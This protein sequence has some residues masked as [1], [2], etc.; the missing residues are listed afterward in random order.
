MRKLHFLRTL[1]LVIF[2]TGISYAQDFSNKGKDFWVGYGYH[3]V[4]NGNNA[5]QMVLYFAADQNT[6][7]TVTIPGL[8]YSQNY[9]VAANSVLTS[10]PLPKTG[11]QDARLLSESIAG[12][13]KGIHIVSDKPIVAYAHIYNASVS[14]ASILFPTA[15]LGK[16]YY[17][18]NYTNISNT[19][20]SNCWFYVVAV[21]TGTTT[22][23][24]TPSAATINHS[25]GIPF[26][27]TLQQGQI[28]N[29]MGQ[30]SGNSG[31]DLTGSKIQSINTGAGCKRIGVFSGSGRISITCNG[32]SS[33]SDNYMVQAFPKTAWGKKFLTVSTG[34]NQSNNIYRIC[35]SDPTTV[36][37]L[38]GAPIGLPLQG[39]FYYEIA[40]SNTPKKIE[41]DKPIMVAQYMTSAGACGN[42]GSPGDP[43]VIYLS[44]VEQ[45]INKVLWNATPNFSIQQHY[46]NVVIPNSGT[47]ISSFKLDGVQV[48]PGLFTVHPQDPAYSYLVQSVSAG[49]HTIE[50]DSGFNAIAYG[51][52]N[53]ESYGYN[54]GTNIKDIYQF[55]SIQ[56]PEAS[57]NFP[58][59]CIGTPFHFSMTFPYQPTSIKWQFGAALNAQGIT[60]VTIP[61]PVP[62]S[63][64]VVNGRTL[65]TYQLPGTYQISTA[66]TYPIR[67]VATNP[68]PDGCG[69]IQEIDFDL[70]V[71]GKPVADFNFSSNGCINS[72]VLF[73]DNS[74]SD[75]RSFI[76]WHW[77]F[78]DATTATITNP[79]H[80]YTAPGSYNVK[81]A[82]TT[83]IGCVSDTTTHVVT[84]ND[85]PVALFSVSP[86]TCEDQVVTFTD[87]S[88][89]TSGGTLTQ[90]TW[91]F[92]DG[93]PVVVRSTST[94]ETHTYTTPGNYIATL[95]VVSSSGCQSILFSMP[96]T[97]YANP[98]VDYN[99]P[100]ACMPSGSAQFND[101]SSAPAGSTITS[102]VWDFGDASTSTLQNPLHNYTA[103]GPF[104]IS[105]TVTT[106]NGCSA[107]KEQILNTIY[108]EPVAAFS[109]LPQVCIGSLIGFSDNSTASGS[110]VTGWNWDFGDGN[111]STLQ[112]PTHI[113]ASAGSYTVT[114]HVTSA[115]GCQTVSN[116]ATHTV[117]VNPLP[118]A[119]ISGTTT[120]CLN[121]PSPSI[122]FTGVIGV[123]PF[124]FTYNINGGPDLIAV[125][126][127]GNSVNVAVPTSTAGTF[128]YNLISVKEGSASGCV[129]PQT[130]SASVTV[131]QLPV[132][133]IGG[134]TTVCL[135]ASAPL[136]TFTGT[137]G[138]APYTFSYN[139][140]GGAT[141]TVTTTIGNSVTVPVSTAT[142]GTFTYNLLSIQESSSNLCSQN[143]SGSA[144][145]TV[146]ALPT[147]TIS[148]S[149]EVCL[150]AASP[151]ITFS[152]A[153]GSAPY[154]FNYSI[155]GGATQ[156]INS[157]TSNSVTIPVS[158]T[159]AGTFS[160]SLI[161]VT[162]GSSNS[163]SQVQSGTADVIVNP[164]PTVD[165]SFTSPQ[166]ET[167]QIAFSDL[168]VA[169][170]GVVNSW[171]WNFGD[172]A[173]GAA[174]TST[175]Q[176][177]THSYSTPGTYTVSLAVNTDKSCA[178]S[179]FTNTVTISPRPSAGFI[180]PEVCL[181][182]LASPFVDTSSVEGGTIVAWEWNF[183]DANATG[184]NPNTSTLQ[185]PTHHFTAVGPYT[186]QLIVTSNTGCKDTIQQTFTV[187][188]SVPIAGFTVQ[189][190]SSLC[191]NQDVQIKDASTVDYGS[192]VK[193]EIYWDYLNNPTIKTT[194]DNPIPGQVYNHTYPEFGTPFTKTYQIRYVAYS[195]ISCVN[196]T[197]QT[198]TVLATP[199]LQFNTIPFAC[200]NAPAFQITQAQLMNGLPGAGV[201]S[202]AGVTGAGLF[203]PSTGPGLYTVRYTYTGTNG[204]ENYLEQTVN[205]FATPGI[206]AG[207]DKFVLEGGQVTLSPASNASQPLTFSWTP[208]IGLNDPTIEFPT[209]S[210]SDDVTY[211]LT[212]TTPQGCSA[213]D[214]VFVKVLKSLLIPNIFS[215]NGD[216][217]HDR[218]EIPY[219]ESYPGCTIEVVNRYGQLVFRSIGYTTPWDG[220]VNGKDVPVGTYYYVID[221][222]NGRSR[223]NGYV[224]VIR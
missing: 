85:P 38:N 94:I 191:S 86:T 79:S 64:A 216:G 117:V 83:D 55:L 196:T 144:I 88:S 160:Y 155:N 42:G 132:A 181:T 184:S 15:T 224:D 90:W 116:F 96:V 48:S 89:I 188:G 93:S 104:N 135:N 213:S 53:A 163:C 129:Q 110:T 4:M 147:A 149:T 145:V 29:I 222:K 193:V 82:V 118:T 220:K 202:G 148:G 171:Q 78:G 1:L 58:A 19:S 166:C 3:Q 108:P 112:N 8:G 35:V 25:A 141:Q 142:A 138:V 49:K 34:G 221:P 69:G 179:T 131:N 97:I 152:G 203:N 151:T 20:N 197:T 204:C 73:T 174:N 70:Q 7:V 111:T 195:G 119:N 9:F 39:N 57:V 43:E 92:G 180:L 122:V 37:T 215:P 209:A 190:A 139:I 101:L 120:V 56:N 210:P 217:S 212:V 60:D 159:T 168:S 164:L 65:Y 67:V 24:I 45:N 109:S 134:T 199:S 187:N 17:S 36:V 63:T 173:S 51:Y 28:Y 11:A 21:D 218:W 137:S 211:T 44:P 198:I 75:G 121:S 178:S 154:T 95:A 103:A 61:S 16:E 72:P 115:E 62:T 165:F 59:T 31:V 10:N 140:N 87:Q 5:Q 136:I 23:E 84:I 175:L 128:T 183:G 201:F 41:A 223:L 14:G 68:T 106:N 98:V 156:L 32:T 71:Y 123:A 143:Q 127:T 185:N 102:W 40:A 133:T 114:L 113:Y 206:N 2:T 208:P 130:S 12:E 33:S 126:T 200:S 107:I 50:S 125:T 47:A 27:V 182:D 177:P 219:L 99:L 30:L 167:G 150:N 18:V 157:G 105:L 80:T 124:T 46:Y 91:D 22:V 194:D 100:V 158:T 77:N 214:N 6:N 66:G 26:L 52:G 81:H 13:N 153:S 74:V 169:N 162:E 192:L 172:P 76:S 205:I 170:A 189:N 161:N 146:K 176:N 186:V 207:P 54:A